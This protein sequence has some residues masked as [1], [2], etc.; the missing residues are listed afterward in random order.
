MHKFHNSTD[1]YLDFMDNK[2]I[3]ALYSLPI[4]LDHAVGY[5]SYNHKPY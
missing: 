2:R 1:G 5:N 3:F 4:V